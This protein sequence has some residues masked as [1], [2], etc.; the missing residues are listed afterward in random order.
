[1]NLSRYSWTIALLALLLIIGCSG[2]GNSP[3]TPDNNPGSLDTVPITGLVDADGILSATG[4]LGAYELTI[5]PE[6]MTAEL[7]S[8]RLSSIGESFIVNGA[9]FFEKTPCFDCIW[10]DSITLIPDGIKLIFKIEHPLPMGDTGSPPSAGN[11]LDLNVFD[12]AALIQPNAN[13]PTLYPLT[14]KSIYPEFLNNADGL[15]GELDNIIT[16]DNELLPYVLVVDDSDTGISTSNIFEMGSTH[17]FDMEFLDFSGPLTFDIYVTFGYGV[18]A[19]YQTRFEPKYYNPE[20]NRKA[21]WKVDAQALGM[22]TASD[23]TTTVDIE[24]EVYDWQIGATVSSEPNFAD[25]DPAHVYAAS[26]V[27]SVSVEIPAMTGSLQSVAGNANSSGTG[28]PN[29]PLIYNIPIANENLLSIGQYTGLVKVLDD[30]PV[31]LPGD[32]RDILIDSLDGVQLD[33]YEMPEYATYQTFN[34]IVVES[35]TDYCWAK[36]WG[37]NNSDISFSVSTDL[38]GNAFVCGTFNETVNF[39]PDGIDY[40][41]AYFDYDVFLSKFDSSGNW[42]WTKTWGGIGE[43]TAYSVALDQAGNVYVTGFF[44]QTVD[45]NPDG[46]E[47]QTSNGSGDVFL[48]KFDNSGNWLWTKTWGGPDYEYAYSVAL[49]QAGNA[50]VTG[51]FEDTVNFNPDGGGTQTSNGGDDVFLSKFDSSGNWLWSKTWGGTDDEEG[52]SVSLDNAG[53]AFVTG[54]FRETVDFNPDGGGTQSS[55]GASDVFLSKF[56]SNGNWQWS[57][58]WGGTSSDDGYSVSADQAGNIF[59]TGYFYLTVDFNPDGGGTQTSIGGNDTYI[60][61]FDTAGTWLWTKTWGSL[62]SDRGRAVALDLFGNAYVT[63]YFEGTVD[64]NPDGG[65]TQSSS[66]IW[67]IYLSKLDS[68]GVWQWTKTWGGSSGDNGNSV[69]LDLIGNA[70]VTGYYRNTVDFNPD[71]G[72]PHTAVA[73]E[74][75]FLW[76]GNY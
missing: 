57:K 31:L 28:A 17:E 69:T 36:T 46:G 35:C 18:S 21:A 12:M 24:V 37:G 38:A 19:T 8:K 60:S 3:V 73:F 34:V 51:F 54:Y 41:T 33:K 61:K 64:F 9:V 14:S 63:G 56:D 68:S 59:V 75:A 50:H 74:D 53:N 52:N 39:N 55:N 43:D 2:N 26:E 66:G 4:L 76:K 72:D 71:S 30:R 13:T 29:D 40:H 48:S 10:L 49:D 22:W 47:T 42:L 1:M 5:N 20:F 65:G 44:H 25:A 11:R 45:F 67:D 15:T 6:N 23:N 32:N 16:S 27:Q 62:D 7:V 58:T 70:Y